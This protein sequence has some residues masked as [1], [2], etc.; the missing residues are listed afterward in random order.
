MNDNVVSFSAKGGSGTSAS[1]T[2]VDLKA[3]L[4]V[5]AR[6]LA[7]FAPYDGRFDL[8][9][10]GLQVIRTSQV[11]EE[12]THAVSRPAM[13]I[14]AQGAK[15]VMLGQE[16]YEYGGSRMVVY[17]AEVPIRA[18]IIKASPDEPF[19]GLVIEI[20]P[21]KLTELVLRV[22]PLG[23]PRI[24]ETRAIHVGPSNPGIVKAAARIMDLTL[25]H[26]APDWGRSGASH[27]LESSGIAQNSTINSDSQGESELMRHAL[28]QEDIDLLVPLA[29][30]EI[31]IRLLR[32]PAGP[33]IAQIGISDSCAH[34]IARAIT[35]LKQHFA[36]PVKVEDL[37]EL[38]HMSPS[39][40]HQ[41][42]KSITAMS[43]LQ[44]QKSLRLQEARHLMFSQMLDVST[45]ALEVG[46]ASTSQ[47]S[48]E[49]SR[50]FGHP[51]GR[52]IARLQSQ[53]PPV[54]AAEG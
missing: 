6:K 9:V 38:A 37:A 23:V 8:P 31:L 52:D 46:Y 32:S 51:P 16:V 26:V 7:R 29:L 15:R 48:R 20:D 11:N 2:P 10:P 49:Y 41:H 44:F 14:V 19:L 5:L 17:A 28:G 33:A 13:C 3:G 54:I 21:E 40:F 47:F 50:F 18:N 43:P 42:F 34:K 27:A 30:D 25:E 53:P 4:E 45:A 22:F 36:E 39:S 24:P 12:K 35:W 1:T